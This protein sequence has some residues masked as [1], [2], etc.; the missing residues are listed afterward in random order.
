MPHFVPSNVPPTAC[1]LEGRVAT[2]WL[3]ARAAAASAL[4]AGATAPPICD[5]C[6]HP[7]AAITSTRAASPRT[8]LCPIPRLQHKM[9]TGRARNTQSGGRE[10]EPFPGFT[11]SGQAQ[12]RYGAFDLG[13]VRQEPWR[14]HELP[15]ELLG[16]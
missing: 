10:R 11:S 5:L 9:I 1:V 8:T 13:A 7:P 16:R 2:G 4:G 6:R 14:K 3:A 12:R 15:A